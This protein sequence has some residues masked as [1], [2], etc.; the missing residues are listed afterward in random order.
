MLVLTGQT[1][2]L[3]ANRKHY[4]CM[5]RAC[6]SGLKVASAMM[7]MFQAGGNQKHR[8]FEMFVDS[9]SVC[10]KVSME[11]MKAWKCL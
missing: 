1:E 2:Y 5:D 11:V 4:M 10:E 9:G 8:L 3:R 6:K 7:D